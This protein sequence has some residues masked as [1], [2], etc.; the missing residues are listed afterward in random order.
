MKFLSI[1]TLNEA[2]FIYSVGCSD[3]FLL[4]SAVDC[5]NRDPEEVVGW[6]IEPREILKCDLLF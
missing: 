3:I 1:D 2:T 6:L 5:R 4:D